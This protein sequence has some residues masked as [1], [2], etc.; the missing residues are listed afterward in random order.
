MPRGTLK[1]VGFLFSPTMNYTKPSLLIADQINHLKGRG[2]VIV[3]QA[4]AEHY[5][6]NI[7]Y[8]RLSAYL[9]RYRLLPTD[10]YVAGTTFED[11]LDCYLFDREFRI[12]LFDAIERLEVAFRTQLIYQPAINHGPFWFTERSFFHD[13]RQWRQHL[14]RLDSEVDRSSETFL[15][16]FFNKYDERTPPAW[17]SFEVVSLGLLSKVYKNLKPSFAPKKEIS[18]HFGIS[19]PAVFE[20]WLRSIT[21]VRNICAHH[22]RLWNRTL[23]VTPI[24]FHSPTNKW[25]TIPPANNDKIYYLLCCIWYML[26][27]VNPGS[28]FVVKLKALFAKYPVVDSTSM[29]FPVNWEAD[30]FWM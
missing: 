23:T 27:E 5:L 12:L 13:L 22:S 7:S 9:Y 30:P 19:Q 29:G 18:K 3:D 1:P 11:V 24:R 14:G 26:R 2:L 6:A 20:S 17:M 8:Y 4:K 28:S 15:K 21:Y 16:H 25:I 10:N